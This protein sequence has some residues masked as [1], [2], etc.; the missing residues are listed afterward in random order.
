MSLLQA[1]NLPVPASLASAAPKPADATTADAK[2]SPSGKAGPSA[3]AGKLL[4]AAE[5]WRK[6]H[7]EAQ[8][9]VEALKTAVMAQCADSP[10]PLLQAI[11]KGLLK[12]DA[13]LKTVDTRLADALAGAGDAADAAAMK[14]ALAKARA[15]VAEYGSYVKGEPLVAHM[16]RNPF[17]TKPGL[18]A[19]LADGLAKAAKAIG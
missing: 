9:R 5:G 3:K 4:E 17:G 11:D 10:P 19:L 6:I 16:D 13:V 2:A 8:A 15:L 14:S 7:G 12:L 1:L 18:Q